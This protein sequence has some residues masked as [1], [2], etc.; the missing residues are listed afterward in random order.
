MAEIGIELRPATLADLEAVLVLLQRDSIALPH[1]GQNRYVDYVKTYADI[2][3]SPND[4]LIVAIRGAEVVGTL[5]VTF[6]PG[7]HGWRAQ[8]EGV[9]VRDDL[10]SL[11][12]GG[13]MMEWVIARARQRGCR[14]VQLTTNVAR[15]DAQR[16]YQRLGFTASH[17][18]MKLVLN[19]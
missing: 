9:R 12:I 13:S 19:P 10:R 7:L 2:E 6:I 17:V 8:V 18:G 5:Q 14:L 3:A 4:E 11:G 1:E 15:K 16:F